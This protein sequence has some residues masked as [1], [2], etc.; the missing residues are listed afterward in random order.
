MTRETHG[1]AGTAKVGWRCAC[2]ATFPTLADLDAHVAMDEAIADAGPH[3][4]DVSDP[5]D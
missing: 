3:R 1:L 5:R 4:P 2:G